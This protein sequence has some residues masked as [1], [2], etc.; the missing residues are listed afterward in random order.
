MRHATGWAREDHWLGSASPGERRRAE[1]FFSDLMGWRR[2]TRAPA[3][4]E[5]LPSIGE[6]VTPHAE[7]LQ[8]AELED[9]QAVEFSEDFTPEDLAADMV[10]LEFVLV[11]DADVKTSAGTTRFAKDSAVKVVKWDNTSTAIDGT[12]GGTSVSVAKELIAPKVSQQVSTARTTKRTYAVATPLYVTEARTLRAWIAKGKAEGRDQTANYKQLNRHLIVE[13]MIN[14]FDVEIARWTTFYDATIGDLHQWPP[15]PPSW[16]KSMMIE[17]ST[18]GTAGKYLVEKPG[19]TPVM[20]RFNLLQAIDDWGPQQFLMIQEIEPGLLKKHGLDKIMDDRAALEKEWQT[21]DAKKVRRPAEDARLKHIDKLKFSDPDKR[22]GPHW[23]TFYWNYPDIDLKPKPAGTSTPATS[24]PT[25]GTTTSSDT[26]T[27][28]A[29]AA[30]GG[31]AKRPKYREIVF[32]FL[33]DGTPKRKYSYSFWIRTGVRWLFEKRRQTP[34]WSDAVRAYNG[35]GARA[36]FYRAVVLTRARAASIGAGIFE[37]VWAGL[38]CWNKGPAKTKDGMFQFCA[39]E[40][41]A[42]NC[43]PRC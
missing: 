37:D 42:N 24:T 38:V 5:S 17:E 18:A 19:G 23:R 2:Q 20:N 31:G 13:M 43:E 26:G 8:T 1:L 28:S 34:T 14:R 29:P 35:E 9:L 25:S 12:I 7:D 40:R 11:G 30:P 41:V 36:E 27:S 4:P 39:F 10:G 15:L 33:E 3:L 21:L 6:S 22:Q 32:A 16:V